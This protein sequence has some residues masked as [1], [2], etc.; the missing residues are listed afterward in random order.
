MADVHCQ[1]VLFGGTADNGYARLL[2]PYLENE[3]A[4]KRITLIEGPPFAHELADI[5][6]R[7]CTASLNG[8]F[9]SQKLLNLKRR[10]SFGIIPPTPSVQYATAAAKAP[11]TSS[12][13][14]TVTQ[15]STASRTASVGVLLNGSGQR[16]DSELQYSQ[17]DL[18]Y[19]KTRKLCNRYYLLGRCNYL[20]NYGNCQHEHA[21]ELSPSRLV[22][23]REL[24]RHT[25]CQ[26]GIYCSEQDCIAGHRC[27]W[28][29]R[30]K[31][32]VGNC[33]FPQAMHN[34]DRTIVNRE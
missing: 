11:S 15:S 20:D 24:A 1:Q 18:L 27:P 26:I 28:E 14:K 17:S 8:V 21:E 3:A 7:F 22:A 10:V 23:L 25:A 33:R 32:S 19:L 16:V 4:R 5:K 30:G 13:T 9:R 6:D 29:K 12:Q 34:V 2:A 31:C